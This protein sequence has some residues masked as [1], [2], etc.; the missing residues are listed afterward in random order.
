MRAD[1]EEPIE[2]V[3]ASDHFDLAADLEAP[4]P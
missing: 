2:G 1:F 3:W 4:H